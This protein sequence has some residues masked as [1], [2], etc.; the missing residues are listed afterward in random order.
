[1]S[2]TPSSIEKPQGVEPI[3]DHQQLSELERNTSAQEKQ[4][5][6]PPTPDASPRN[7]HG[8]LVS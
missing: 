7:I 6:S 1:M 3:D 2:S 8:F 4:E 5:D